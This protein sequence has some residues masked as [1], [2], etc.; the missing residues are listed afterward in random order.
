LRW[1]LKK[2]VMTGSKNKCTKLPFNFPLPKTL[3]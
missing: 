2:R 1:N 3:K